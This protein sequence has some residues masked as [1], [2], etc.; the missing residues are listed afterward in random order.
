MSRIEHRS[1]PGLLARLAYWIVR[2]RLGQVPEPMEV[3]AHHE[4][5]F[6]GYVLF[7]RGLDRAKRVSARLK[8][9]A[10]LKAAALVGCP[11]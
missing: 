1:R 6:L 8:G 9:L 11:F 5:V 4:Q 2:R 3:I 7:E 10:Q